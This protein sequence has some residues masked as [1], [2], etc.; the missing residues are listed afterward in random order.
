[1]PF[2]HPGP[3][4]VDNTGLG[5]SRLAGLAEYLQPTVKW[6]RALSGGAV[7]MLVV[8]AAV[9]RGFYDGHGYMNPDA[10]FFAAAGERLFSGSW[11]DAFADPRVQAGPL[12]QLAMGMLGRLAEMLA[13]D[14]RRVLLPA[15]GVVYTAALVIVL[16]LVLAGRGRRSPVLE[17]F[18]AGIALLGGLTWRAASSGH[19]AEAFIPL[20]WILAALAAKRSRPVYAGLLLGVAA[21]LNVWGLLGAPVLMLAPDIRSM[22]SGGA[23]LGG[24]I[25]V[26]Y[27]PFVVF[28]KVS[29]LEYE[30]LITPHSPLRFFVSL[31]SEVGW[32][33]RLAQ[34]VAVVAVAA[35]A[36]ALGRRSDNAVWAVPLVVIAVRLAVDPLVWS[37]YWVPVG[38]VGLVGALAL[39]P[40]R[41]GWWHAPVA[42]GFSFVVWVYY[43]LEPLPRAAWI[44]TVAVASIAAG[45][46]ALRFNRSERLSKV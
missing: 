7:L 43:F 16:R 9:V 32:S 18:A 45:L 21:G 31:G 17:L 2:H 30:W 27:G 40:D 41:L 26:L 29:T 1:M 19:L 22:F 25:V 44:V 6:I 8:G 39:L 23:V 10:Y 13:V 37:Y 28:G 34:G 42:V 36:A 33:A 14:L 35:V 3:G 20:L 46:G 38:T 5:G 15:V 11:A 24:V 12:H 4:L